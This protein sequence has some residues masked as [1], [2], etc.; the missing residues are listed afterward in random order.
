MQCRRFTADSRIRALYGPRWLR[1][2]DDR[3][4]DRLSRA[5]RAGRPARAAGRSAERAI[6]FG[7]RLWTDLCPSLRHRITKCRDAIV[8]FE[9][10]E[11]RGHVV[12]DRLFSYEERVANLLVGAAHHEAIEHFQLAWRKRYLRRRAALSFAQRAELPEH[13]SRQLRIGQY[14]LME[15][16]LAFQHDVHRFEDLGRIGVFGEEG[17]RTDSNCGK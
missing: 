14:G 16:V 2:L 4:A 15:Q 5:G 7:I 1:E 8:D 17:G 9:L 11:N 6:D 10:S 13:S 3:R 12:L